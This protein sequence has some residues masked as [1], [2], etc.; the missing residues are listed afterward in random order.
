[1]FRYA[2]VEL[3]HHHPVDDEAHKAKERYHGDRA[4]E[5]PAM[6]GAGAQSLE[7][8]LDLRTKP[9]SPRSASLASPSRNGEASIFLV[10]GLSLFVTEYPVRLSYRTC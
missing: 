2:E 3:T 5:V 8:R 10:N 6:T 7:H 9:Y 1:M 4:I